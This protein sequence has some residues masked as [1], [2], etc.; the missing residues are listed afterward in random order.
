MNLW[1]DCDFMKCISFLLIFIFKDSYK[2]ISRFLGNWK[3]GGFEKFGFVS[4][5][6]WKNALDFLFNTV[7]PKKA[8]LWGGA[9]NRQHWDVTEMNCSEIKLLLFSRFQ[10][11]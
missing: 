4:V 6:F 11:P 10:N 3:N 7:I 2:F 1:N 5:A 9:I 8:D